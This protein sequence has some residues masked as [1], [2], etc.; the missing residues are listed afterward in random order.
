MK[1]LSIGNSFSQDSHRYL[2]E[3]AKKYGEDVKTVNLLIGGCTLRT[4]YI[5]ML[6]DKKAY[7]FVFNGMSVG[8]AVTMK[9]VLASDD[10]D[11]I[12]FQQASHLSGFEDTYSPYLEELVKFAK[13]YCPKAKIYIHQTW[14]YTDDEAIVKR[15][16]EN[17][18]HMFSSLKKCY[19]N[20]VK[21]IKADGLI[22][23][24]EVMWKAHKDGIE[25]IHRDGSH[26]AL[27]VGRY[28]LALTW[29]K[30][31]FKKDITDNDFNNFDEIVTDEERKIVI[32][33]VNEVTKNYI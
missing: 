23:S 17:A 20:A 11:V 7:S 6:E 30:V 28:A 31:L 21:L 18:E 4:H 25:K 10:W 9:D 24:G 14:V 29:Y 13:K 3:I 26:A 12:T 16:Y 19:K 33:A 8:L 32:N 1:I 22:P 15:G 27:G 5:N 2:A